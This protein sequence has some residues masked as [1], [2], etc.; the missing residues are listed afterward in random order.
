MTD[1]TD[2]TRFSDAAADRVL[3]AAHAAPKSLQELA[4]LLGVA[5][6][7]SFHAWLEA[8]VFTGRLLR[9]KGKRFEA[10]RGKSAVGIYR[11]SRGIG[12]SGG[13]VV[14]GTPG[15]E[16]ID[17]PNGLEEGAQDGDRVLVSVRDEG[18]RRGRRRDDAARGLAGRVLSII[19][20]RPVEAAGVL[21][22][23]QRGDPRVR[24]EG[25]NLPR[26]VWLEH[27]DVRRM[28]PGAVVRV[29]IDRRPDGQGR[30]RGRLL[31]TVGMI[32]DP[33]HDFDNLVALFDFPGTFSDAALAQA[34][35]L[36]AHPP[37]GEFAGRVDLREL[38]VITIDPVDAEDH[39][40]AISLEQLE[41]GITRLGVH[42]ADVA[43]YVTPGSALDEDARFRATS[44]YLPGRVI[45]MLPRE[46][47]AGLCSL[48]D[49]VDRLAKSVFMHF[50]ATGELLRREVVDSVIRVRRFLTYEEVLPVLER[51][52]TCGDAALDTMLLQC[53]ELADRLLARRL[54]RGALILE[55]PRPH[56]YVNKAG[57]AYKI[58]PERHD[59]AHNLIEEFMLIANESVAHFLIERGLPYIGRI[60]PAPAEDSVED[61]LE[62]CDELRLPKPDFDKPGALQKWLEMV[63]QRREGFDAIH[64]ALLRSLTRA[65]YH[66]GPDLH[67]ALAVRHYVHFTSPIRRY[68]DTITHQIIRAYFA[69][70]RKLRWESRKLGLPWADGFAGTAGKATRDGRVIENYETRE[71]SMPQIAAHC[72]D[73]SIKADQGSLAAHQIKILRHMRSRVGE[74]MLGTVIGVSGRGVTVRLD[75]NL[76]E[77]TVDFNDLTDGWVET[78]RFWAHYETGGGVRKIML[79]DRIE[80]QIADI[81]LGSRSMRL[82][83]LGAHSRRRDDRYGRD[84]R[85]RGDRRGR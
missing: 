30:T 50:D 73:R 57:L 37:Q 21:E 48:H 11:R 39:D 26:Y 14:T 32:E 6:D 2:P 61:F 13:Y 81:D 42:I 44:V 17:I 51:K 59:I 65:V 7:D 63:R 82:T 68:P 20:A 79:G 33:L 22:Y 12:R 29:R 78:H 34:R 72:T 69:A 28:K 54:A 43:H 85:R 47:S 80:V 84:R 64:Y 27:H 15:A 76:A 77:G 62:F 75:E 10:V 3:Q 70:G 53:R 45:P 46:L 5:A 40:D 4:D 8:L 25:A 38:A 52:G 9:A 66:A 83:P 41:G 1:S 67:Y 31:G 18:M 24:M 58:E 55:I 16:N 60:H 74:E 56:V 19:E 23:G 71:F 36:P 49:S 35:A